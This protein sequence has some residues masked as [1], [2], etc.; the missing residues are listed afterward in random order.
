MR[1][2]SSILLLV[3]AAMPA[4]G[5]VSTLPDSITQRVDRVFAAFT[6]ETPGCGVGISRN[7]TPAYV[8]TFGMANLEY[9]VPLTPQTVF[10]SGSVAKQ[11][12]AAAIVLLALDGRLSIDDDVRKYVPEVPVFPGGP[13]TIR[14]LLN[15]T[16][17]LRDQWG[18]LGLMNEG[19]GTHVHTPETTV[20]L[21]AHQRALNFPPGT[22]YLYSNTGYT[23]AGVIVTRVSGKSLDAF[24]QERLFRPL[25]MTGTQWR[26]DFNEIVKN[27]ATAY[28]W[29]RGS[30]RT[31]MPITNMIG[32]GGLL[33]TI[34]DMLRWMAN[35]DD[36]K[37]GGV[38]WRDS[39]HVQGRLKSGRTIPYALG[40]IVGS[41]NGAREI[42]HGGSTAG[43]QTWV[44]R[45]PEQGLAIAVLCN[46]TSANPAQLAHQVTDIFIP[47]GT[48]VAET[49]P[50]STALTPEQQQAWAGIW[51]DST[52]DAVIRLSPRGTSVGFGE[53]VQ[54]VLAPLSPTQLRAPSV[55]YELVKAGLKR[56][57]LRIA[58]DDTSAFDE[59]APA[60][61][62]AATLRQY[63]GTY[64]SEELGTSVAIAIE[65]GQL[66][67]LARPSDRIRL[68]PSYRD[69]FLGQGSQAI[70][71]V[72]DRT[73]RVTGLSVFAG[74][75][76]DVRFTKTSATPR[77]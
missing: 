7:G 22:R 13:I 4:A 60:D 53:P 54:V 69:G 72:R 29:G 52:T 39:L 12:T 11:F 42:S 5:Q 1:A 20:D 15:H 48:A 16:S 2:S 9:G 27:R 58:S 56:R 25:G 47:R 44:G 59:V 74:R 77:L 66:F 14:M 40:L 18:L 23:L 43:Y 36:P 30:Y 10:E 34:E 73:G 24:T 26:D 61:T 33:F 62:S 3:L 31:N 41:Y 70:R 63:V 21:V 67:L 64:A 49:W 6:S 19:P 55:R 76:L 38:A 46:V 45:Y 68:R 71:F 50:T 37:V 28:G 65:N 75:V 57:V 17:G 51:R 35:L 8:K 32:N